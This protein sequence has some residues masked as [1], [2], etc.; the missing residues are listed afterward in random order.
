[1]NVEVYIAVC[2]TLIVIAVA[3]VSVFLI[4]ALWQLRRAARA[5]EALSTRLGAQV[6]RL[7]GLAGDD[8]LDGGAGSDT[9]IGGAGNDSYVLDSKW[10]SANETAG[11]GTDRVLTSLSR[12]L[13]WSKSMSGGWY[14]RAP[15]ARMTPLPTSRLFPPCGA[16]TSTVCASTM[17]VMRRRWGSAMPPMEQVMMSPGTTESSIRWC[18]LNVAFIGSPRFV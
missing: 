5:L 4:L 3:G 15:G 2:L 16:S 18:V 1:M 9:L 14:G 10:D 12:T 17:R 13:G 11:E 6:G 7:E 8:W